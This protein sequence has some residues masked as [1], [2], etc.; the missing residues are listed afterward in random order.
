MSRRRT[1]GDEDHEDQS[2]RSSLRNH[3][4]CRSWVKAPSQATKR[5]V[6]VLKA[7]SLVIFC[8]LFS[9]LFQERVSN[10]AINVLLLQN[11]TIT[12][13]NT[14]VNI[15]E[16]GGLATP[17]ELIMYKAVLNSVQFF[18]VIY[19]SPTC[20]SYKVLYKSIS[21]NRHTDTNETFRTERGENNVPGKVSQRGGCLYDILR[22]TKGGLLGDA[23]GEDGGLVHIKLQASIFL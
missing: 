14:R 22:H 4:P 18:D 16:S 19:N 20:F 6:V 7:A 2:L 15:L 10:F 5:D 8:V 13:Q 17:E 1:N 9:S 21:T 23:L 3:K 12:E 11:A